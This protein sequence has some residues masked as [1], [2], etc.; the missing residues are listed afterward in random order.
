MEE[1]EAVLRRFVDDP[2][3]SV[4]GQMEGES[5]VWPEAPDDSGQRWPV[6]LVFCPRGH[7][8]GAI[9]LSCDEAKQHWRLHGD[10]GMEVQPGTVLGIHRTAFVCSTCNRKHPNKSANYPVRGETLLERY[11][12]AIATNVPALRLP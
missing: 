4:H 3:L 1:L 10:P 7:E 8:V 12:I 2:R 6:K 11:A 5:L 9:N